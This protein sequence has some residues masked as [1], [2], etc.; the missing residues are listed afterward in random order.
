MKTNFLPIA[1]FENNFVPFV[2]AKISIAT[3]ALHYGTAAFGGL[4]AFVNSENNQKIAT[5]FRLDL[6]TKR[7]SQ[8][9]KFLGFEISQ[10]KIKDKILE[11]T[12]QNLS[13]TDNSFYIRPLVYVSDLGISPRLHET[14]FDFLIYGLM[15]GNYLAEDGVKVCFSSWMRQSD[16]SFPMRGKISGGYITSALAKTEAVT[17]GFEE[18]ILLNSRGKVCEGTG[19]NLFLVRTIGGEIVLITP[20][21]DQDIL[22]GIT[23]ISVIQIAQSLGIKV[24][25]RV[26][27]KSELLIADEVFLTGTAAQITPINQIENYTLSKEKPI[28][29]EIKSIFQK[30]IQENYQGENGEYQNWTMRISL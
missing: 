5:L 11:F 26:V 6:H 21:V 17:R 20:S 29:Q 10:V 12:K 3:G 23:R 16:A 9:A 4:R 14:K 30:I 18:A 8:S 28:C 27:D 19:M 25:E 24:L 1:F 2:D 22:E 15:L 13:Q 7:L